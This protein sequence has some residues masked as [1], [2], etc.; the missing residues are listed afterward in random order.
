MG[1]ETYEIVNITDCAFDFDETLSVQHVWKTFD[2]ECVGKIGPSKNKKD[3]FLETFNNMN[4]SGTL[5]GL[6]GGQKRV[7]EL[8]DFFKEL[9][10][11]CKLHIITF[12]YFDVIMYVL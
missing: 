4:S 10:D 12:N 9:Q 1:N 8:G 3:C 11:Y 7:K 6:F 5:E 2:T